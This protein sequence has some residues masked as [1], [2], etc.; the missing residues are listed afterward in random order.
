MTITL[1]DGSTT[2]DPRLDRVIE[3]DPLSLDQ[4]PISA[5]LTERQIEKPRSYQWAIDVPAPLDQGREG[6][7]VGFAFTH[8]LVAR[9]APVTGL[10]SAYALS[11]YRRA[12]DLDSFP[13]SQPGTSVL[14]GAKAMKERG[15]YSEYRWVD[16][17][18]E[19][20]SAVGYKGPV[21]VG[22]N[23]YEGMYRTDRNGWITPSG[24][25][26]G[27][28]AWLIYGVSITGDFYYMINSWGRGF[29]TN[30]RG[31]VA[32]SVMRELWSRRGE[33]CVPI[34]TAKTRP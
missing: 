18:A 3:F 13:N 1:R 27:G 5:Y 15:F 17:E 23:W 29:G 6:A 20:A 7:C 31:R 22:T 26:V 34:R 2:E 21:I 12:Q 33:G 28:H 14:A 10:T 32:R 9:P 30:G 25:L 24:R 4:Y 8:D 16:S 11:V 19:L